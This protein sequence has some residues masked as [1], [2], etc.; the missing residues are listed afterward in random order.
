M[1]LEQFFDLIAYSRRNS[2]S[3][4]TYFCCKTLHT[5]VWQCNLLSGRYSFGYRYR[6]SGGTDWREIL[7]YGTVCVFSPFVGGAPRDPPNPKFSHRHV[8]RIVFQANALVRIVVDTYCILRE[9]GEIVIGVV[10][11]S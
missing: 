3:H 10:S 5:L 1:T 9:C 6:D 4:M 7:L 11:S 8:A 2:S